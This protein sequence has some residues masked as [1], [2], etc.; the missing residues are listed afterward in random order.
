MRGILVWKRPMKLS[1]VDGLIFFLNLYLRKSTLNG[2]YFNVD[3]MNTFYK[4]KV[5][6]NLSRGLLILTI[7]LIRCVRVNLG[8]PSFRR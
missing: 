3:L 8:L 6:N 2:L 5:R 1:L 7:D 4:V